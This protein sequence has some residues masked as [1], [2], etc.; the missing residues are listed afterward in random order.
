MCSQSQRPGAGAAGA[1]ADR[2][3]PVQLHREDDDQHHAEP[4]MRHR[5][6]GDRDRGRDLVD[7]GIA[8]IAGD[9]AE[10]QSKRKADQGCGDRQRHGVADRAQ[11]LRQH[12]PAGG[13][14]MAEIAVDRPPQPEPEL[15]RQRTV[16]AVGDAQLVGQFLRRIGRQYR[17][18]GIAG[19]DV[20]QQKAHQRHADDDRDH[21]DDTAGNID[22]HGWPS[23]SSFSPCGRRWR[24]RSA[25]RMRG[26]LSTDRPGPLT[27]RDASHRADPLPQGE[28]G[29][30]ASRRYGVM[31]TGEKSTNQLFGCT[32][33][34]IFGLIARGATSW[35]T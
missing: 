2:G 28:R 18:Q 24:R 26:F 3:Q 9:Q 15:H 11:H 16:E 4:V 7:P 20:H 32:N 33:P 1:G 5:D 8:E 29:R 17:D 13:D 23:L 34:L 27:R 14:G 19:R 31:V 35:A 30:S 10:E 21:I 25:G 12:R 22:E 6:A